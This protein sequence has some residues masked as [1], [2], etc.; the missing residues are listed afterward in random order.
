MLLTIKLK[1]S[2]KED[3]LDLMSMAKLKNLLCMF[4]MVLC[5]IKPRNNIKLRKNL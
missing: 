4:C 1:L 2:R 5:K 3:L